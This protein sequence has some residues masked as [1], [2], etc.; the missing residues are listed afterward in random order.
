M[1]PGQGRSTVDRAGHRSLRPRRRDRGRR[2]RARAV[3]SRDRA[4]D[5]GGA[6]S[7]GRP[8][9]RPGRAAEPPRRSKG[10]SPPRR[11][12]RASSAG[13][14]GV[15]DTHAHLDALDDP[16]AAVSRALEAGVNRIL[17]VGTTVAGCRTAL[18]LA[19]RHEG[20]YAV[21]GL[22]P[23]EAG[24]V[25]VGDV[26]RLTE[27][28]DHPTRGGRRRDRA[29]LLPRLRAA[30]RPAEALSA[31]ARC[32]RRHGEAGRR[33]H[34]G[35][36]RGHA[37]RTRRLRR[38]G[39][40]PLL[41]VHRSAP[42]GARPRVLRLVRGEHDLPEGGRPA[43]ARPHRSRPTGSWPRQTRRTWR[44]SPSAAGRT[45]PR[46]LFTPL[47]RSPRR[48]GRRQPRS[49]RRSKRTRRRLQPA[50]RDEA[51]TERQRS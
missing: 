41:L 34:S 45:S 27:L 48:A 5:P 19:D 21:L 29:R 18:D 25:A 20:V 38:H 33:S 43:H 9:A 35:G 30:G 17:T 28:L 40:A 22:H 36:R 2:R 8:V 13:P 24:A 16:D 6:S 15:I 14:G 23:H 42:G 11:S 47:R 12:S 26:D 7:A 1:E 51:D 4:A 46:T 10:S 37:R 44:R 32:R 31:P 49:R 3:P 50:V 39:R